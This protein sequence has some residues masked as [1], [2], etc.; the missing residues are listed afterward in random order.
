MNIKIRPSILVISVGLVVA[1]IVALQL[2]QT[3][4]VAAIITAIAGTASKLV[5]SEEKGL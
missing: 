2:G 3:E 4:A 1:L 5:E